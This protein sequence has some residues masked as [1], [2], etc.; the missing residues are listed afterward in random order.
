[1]IGIASSLYVACDDSSSSPGASSSGT[2]G[3]SGEPDSGTSRGTSSSGTTGT[4]SG[5]PPPP[6]CTDGGPAL[7]FFRLDSTR[8]RITSLRGADG[9]LCAG[10]GERY[11]AFDLLDA[12]LTL[13]DT[14]TPGSWTLPHPDVTLTV[15][16]YPIDRSRAGCVCL[17]PTPRETITSG[18]ITLEAVDGG[19]YTGSIELEGVPLE[20]AGTGKV[21]ALVIDCK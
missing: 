7:G 19:T 14:S 5:D 18:K 11:C 17:D 8:I 10:G 9:D 16:R 3:T 6:G 21:S 20:G 13:P 4:A 1:M 2:S 15:E 12:I